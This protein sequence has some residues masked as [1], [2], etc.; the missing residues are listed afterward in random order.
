MLAEVGIDIDLIKAEII[1]PEG[2]EDFDGSDKESL[3]L[4]ASA[5]PDAEKIEEAIEKSSSAGTITEQINS[6]AEILLQKV[7]SEDMLG[8]MKQLF[9]I[10][11][12]TPQEHAA[13]LEQYPDNKFLTLGFEAKRDKAVSYTHLTLPTN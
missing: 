7:V 10:G 1:L 12:L 4:I 2:L 3:D 6:D 5:M 11:D 13:W 8:K 9:G